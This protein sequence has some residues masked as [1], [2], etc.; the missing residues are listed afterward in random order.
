MK[1]QKKTTEDRLK[2][3]EEFVFRLQPLA[4]DD[5]RGER[6]ALR[7]YWSKTTRHY[8]Y[9]ILG[10]FAAIGIP[11][12]EITAALYALHPSHGPLRSLGETCRRLAGKDRDAFEPHFRRL[13]SADN[14]EELAEQ[15][16]RLVRRAD[17]E[18]I[19]VNYVQLLRDLSRWKFDSESV[20]TQWAKDF[21]QAVDPNQAQPSIAEKV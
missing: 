4:I 10:R 6:A 7:R 9:P 21:W 3:A 16:C 19:P 15:L 8:A 13:L 17:K 2:E 1:T 20:K 11:S 5:K 14:L 18:K 12:K